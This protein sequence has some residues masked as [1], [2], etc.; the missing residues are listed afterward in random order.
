MA[1]LNIQDSDIPLLQGKTAI[2]TGGSSGIG[3]AAVRLLA[4]KGATV[5]VLDIN[6]PAKEKE[7]GE[8]GLDPLE[9]SVHFHRCDMTSWEQLRGA[10]D[11]V[12]GPIDYVFA[13]AGVSE[14]ADYFADRLDAD[15]LLAEPA[16]RVLDVN[17]R[18]VYNVVKLAWS[19][20][21]RDKTPGSI[22]ITTSASGYAPE[23]SLPVYS[24]GKLA[25]VGLIRALR[26]VIIRDNITINGVAPAATITN[27]LPAHLAAPIRAQGL[28]VSDAHSVGRALV[29]SAVAKQTRRVQAYG[30]DR[31]VDNSNNADDNVLSARNRWNGRVILT[32]GDTYT[33]VEEPT[34]DLRPFWMGR[35]NDRLTR[36]QQAAT[37]FRPE[38]G[39]R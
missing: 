34:A 4:Q 27:L 1:S 23:Q 28:P 17:V 19:R 38:E 30:R 2:I 32:L 26:S 8:G 22:V 13:N 5:H 37:D 35:E 14:E 24:S 12:D 10:I 25:L 7:E 9:R 18:S 39:D 29:Y 33:E 36:L 15:G 11:S 21:R 20:M 31:N 6:R 3:L 16:Y